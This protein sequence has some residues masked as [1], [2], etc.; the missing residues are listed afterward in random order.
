[1]IAA[2]AALKDKGG[3]SVH[4]ITNQIV[5]THTHVARGDVEPL[6]K[7]AVHS[8]AKQESLI[9]AASAKGPVYRLGRQDPGKMLTKRKKSSSA[10]R[11]SSNRKESDQKKALKNRKKQTNMKR[12]T[13]KNNQQKKKASTKKAKPKN[14]KPAK[15]KQSQKNTSSQKAPK[16]G[17]STSK[18]NPK[19]PTRQR[20]STTKAPPKSPKPS[21][22]PGG[23]G[24]QIWSGYGCKARPPTGWGIRWEHR[25]KKWG[26]IGWEHDFWHSVREKYKNMWGHQVRAKS[27][28]KSRVFGWYLKQSIV[29]VLPGTWLVFSI[30]DCKIT[31]VKYIVFFSNASFSNHGALSDRLNEKI[32]V[33]GWELM[34]L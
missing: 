13:K 22:K 28:Q 8:L 20:K 5:H 1:M 30:L 6:V 16:R 4:D 21:Q 17:T 31:K 19:P 32:W 9:P 10:K 18:A 23:G 15:K 34:Q 25:L 33:F 27:S 26:V 24:R 11:A 3:S 12:E 29:R 2:V 14:Q 7:R